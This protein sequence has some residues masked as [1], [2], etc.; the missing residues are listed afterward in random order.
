MTSAVAGGKTVAVIGGG[1]AGLAAG[2][3]LADVGFN[4]SLF[5]RRPYLGGRASSY[6]HPGTGEVI[7]NCQHVLLGCCT[8]LI[9]FYRRLAVEE[10]IR[11]F[12]GLN[13]IE[14][15]GRRSVISA[16]LL[17]AP[18]HSSVSFLR[19][20]FLSAGDKDAV[21]R[22]LLRLAG[23]LPRDSDENFLHWLECHWQ[24]EAGIE[25]FWKPVL[26]SALNE[27]LD[28]ISVRYAAQVFRESFLKCAAAGYLGIPQVPLSE[29]YS[30]AGEY[31]GDRGGQVLSRCPVRAI[32]SAPN[33]ATVEIAGEGQSK[34]FD[35]VI[36][37]V[38][39]DALAQMLPE[40]AEMSPLREKLSRFETSP[41]TGIHLWF[42]RE[43]TA[44]EHAVLLDRTIQWM[45]NKSK[46][47]SARAEASGGSY[48]ELVVSSSKTLVNKSRQ[49]ILDLAL[50]ELAEFFPAAREAKLVKG[51]VIKEV[52]APYSA[53]P[54]ADSYRSPAATPW[55]RFFLAGDWTATGWPATMEGAVRS[56]YRAA[57][58]VVQARDPRR[59]LKFLVPDMAAQGFM[60]LLAG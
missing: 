45:F 40:A 54:G 5:E 31:I 11:W 6:E 30:V 3:A 50:R 42:D 4:V 47:I 22:A 23:E 20:K 9:D 25:R 39:F 16:G 43:I 24:T 55:P 28:R 21:A 14:P 35:Y 57:E 13:F 58:E 26:V 32:R 51:T 29:L 2:S 8:N 44:L 46:L 56:G 18:F 36:S 38:P 49:E 60:R 34:K 41:I 27:D 37:A 10:K 48:L 59:K 17:P 53:L 33:A 15:G 1:L 19:A 7:D 12:D 52:N